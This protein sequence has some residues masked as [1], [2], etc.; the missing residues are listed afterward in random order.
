LLIIAI[1]TGCSAFE[2][3]RRNLLPDGSSG[4][5]LPQAASS[6]DCENLGESI[7]FKKLQIDVSDSV[8]HTI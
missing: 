3:Q 2:T 5:S 4:K 1:G 8:F 7:N 6:S